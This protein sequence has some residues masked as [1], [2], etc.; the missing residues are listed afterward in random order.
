[1]PERG[2]GFHLPLVN[3]QDAGTHDLGDEGRGV[4]RQRQRQ[5]DEFQE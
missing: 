2:A 4:G 5:G 3:R 1:M